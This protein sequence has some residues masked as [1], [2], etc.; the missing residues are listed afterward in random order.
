MKIED[1]LSKYQTGE[2]SAWAVAEEAG[3]S[4]WEF[5]EILK[6]RDIPFLTDEGE[7]ERQLGDFK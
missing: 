5:L 3:L 7:L 2:T 6:D 1:A 4:L